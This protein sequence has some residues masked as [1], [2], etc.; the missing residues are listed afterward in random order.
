MI[1]TP[2]AK[3]ITDTKKCRRRGN[4]GDGRNV[5]GNRCPL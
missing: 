3:E 2:D 1:E 4:A 5:S